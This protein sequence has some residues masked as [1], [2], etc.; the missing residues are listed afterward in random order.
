M[1][2][3]DIHSERER[4]EKSGSPINLRLNHTIFIIGTIEFLLKKNW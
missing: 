3:Y 1:P 2:K 4:S